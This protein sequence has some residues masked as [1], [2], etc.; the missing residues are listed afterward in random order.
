M[1]KVSGVILTA[2]GTQ[3]GLI[4]NI[5]SKGGYAQ[6][7]TPGFIRGELKCYSDYYVGLG[8]ETSGSIISMHPLLD[9]GLMIL[10]H[11]LTAVAE[12]S[13]TT[14]QV[15]DLDSAS[16]YG[17]AQGTGTAGTYLF[18]CGATSTG[19]YII[20]TNPTTP[21]S[22]DTDAQITITTGAQTLAASSITSL[23]TVYVS[24]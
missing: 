14:F 19:P 20:G 8:T 11:V 13:G 12:T 17:A 18:G 21:T 3:S 6:W 24:A 16:R 5:N 22:T 15:G 1:A 4:G 9:T 23:T 7:Q 2:Y 10:Y